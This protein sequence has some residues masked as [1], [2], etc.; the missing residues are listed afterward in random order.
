MKNRSIAFSLIMSITFSLFTPVLHAQTMQEGESATISRLPAWT[1]TSGFQAAKKWW[2][3]G[4]NTSVL[5]PEELAAFNRLKKA[6]G[7][8]ALV[9]AIIIFLG[10]AHAATKSGVAWHKE[11]RE[12][13]LEAAEKQRKA[14]QEKMAAQERKEEEDKDLKI[15]VTAMYITKRSFGK[16]ESVK[17]FAELVGLFNNDPQ[18]AADH[19]K[20]YIHTRTPAWRHEDLQ[21]T[22]RLLENTRQAIN[23]YNELYNRSVQF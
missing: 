3:A 4:R 22:A 2:L 11:Y 17:L 9:N 1:K 15:R 13:Q 8:V 6:V 18:A 20:T 12:E 10:I 19:L 16:E 7:I 23:T 21:E 5:T 14:A